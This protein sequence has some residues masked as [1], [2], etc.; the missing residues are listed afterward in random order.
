[1]CGI[2]G[3]LRFDG[4]PPDLTRVE[5]MMDR[6]ARRGPDH[7]GSHS[8]GPVALGHRR[9][10]IIDLSARSNQP[11][12]DTEL[13]LSLVFNGTIYNYRELRAELAGMGY[14]FFSDGDTEVILKAY[15]A[16][17]QSCV[18]R[19][20]GMFAFAVWDVA[21]QELFLA[22]DRFGIK[23]LYYN[24]A[25]GRL[26]FASTTQALLAAGDVDTDLDP[27]ALHHHFT[28][29][30]VVPAPRTVLRGIRKLAPAHSMT[31]GLDG[32]PRLRRYWRLQARRPERPMGEWEWAE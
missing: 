29:H 23:P 7:S 4:H 20:V 5:R 26:R 28:L 1:M 2:C 24:L 10:A 17:G 32:R 15:A 12:V 18:E 19:L 14:H 25:R 21:R 6:L 16:W 9:L 11:L 22:R 27:V 3:E 31:V 13:G 30:A 8:D